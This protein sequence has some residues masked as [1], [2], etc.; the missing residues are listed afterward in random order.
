VLQACKPDSVPCRSMVLSFIWDKHYCLPLSAYPGPSGEQP[1]SDPI[2]GIS[3]H[4]VYPQAVLPLPTVSSYL[5]F[6]PFPSTGAD[7]S[8]FLWHSLVPASDGQPAVS[9]YVALCCPDFPTPR[10]SKPSSCGFQLLLVCTGFG[11]FCSCL[12]TFSAACSPT[13]M[14]GRNM[15]IRP[16]VFALLLPGSTFRWSRFIA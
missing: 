4:K 3:A 9:R 11:Y 6:S 12:T 8:Y 14:H 16:V 13:G 7:G 2:H 1:S 15:V 10:R 5:T